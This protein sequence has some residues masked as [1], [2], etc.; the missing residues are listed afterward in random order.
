MEFKIDQWHG[1]EVDFL[2]AEAL[3]PYQF[4]E[5]ENLDGR[6]VASAL[7]PAGEQSRTLTTQS[8][9]MMIPGQGFYEYRAEWDDESTPRQISTLYRV[10]AGIV[11]SAGAWE[12]NIRRNNAK[13]DN[14]G[15]W[16]TE[17]I[18]ET[19][20]KGTW[21]RA[22]S[23]RLVQ[24]ST[25][26]SFAA[27][28]G[29]ISGHA[30]LANYEVG[31]IIRVWNTTSNNGYYTV[32]AKEPAA[33]SVD[34][35]ESL[36]DEA[37]V[38]AYLYPLPDIS[39]FAVN[40]DLRVSNGN[41]VDS[42]AS[43]WYGHIKRDFWGQGITYASNA[44]R[45]NQPPMKE[46]YNNW[47]LQN[48]ELVAPTV[49]AGDRTGQN[50]SAANQIAIHV[51]GTHP[52]NWPD[53]A[54]DVE[55]NARDR[56]TATFVYD[57]VQESE[58]GKLSSGDIGIEMSTIITAGD[59]RAFMVEAYTGA[60]QASWN[61]RITAIR[62]YYKFHDDPDWYEIATLDINK[63]W[64]ESEIVFD[65]ENTGYWIPIAD[66][67]MDNTGTTN[68]SGGSGTT[69]NDDGHGLATDD[70][71]YFLNT[72]TIE[73]GSM[74]TKPSSF[75]TNT[76]T[77]PVAMVD[78]LGVN[79]SYNSVEWCAGDRSATAVA[80]FYI[81]FTGEKAFSYFTNTGRS[82]KIKVPAIRWRACD[83]D[84]SK[85][86]YGN[87]DTK[88]DNDQTIRERSRIIETSAG[89]PDTALLSN[90]KD[91][92]LYLGDEIKAIKYYNGYWWV[93]MERHVLVIQPGTLRI[94]QAYSNSGC[95]WQSAFAVTPYGM[96]VADETKITILPS[97]EELTFLKRE[98][99]QALTFFECNM[100]Y[101]KKMNEL[102][103][104]PDSSHPGDAWLEWVYSFSNKSWRR[105]IKT[106]AGF[107]TF[108]ASNYHLNNYNASEYCWSLVT[109]GT[110][111][112][113]VLEISEDITQTSW[114]TAIKTKEYDHD[115][116]NN[117]KQ[118]GSGYLVHKSSGTITVEIYLDGSSTA[119][120]TREISASSSSFTSSEIQL[121]V[122][123]KFLELRFTTVATTTVEYKEFRIPN[124][125][126]TVLDR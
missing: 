19:A 122:Q 84:G 24:G 58:L 110:T 117:E 37:S 42:H 81:P 6:H 115:F 103:F 9:L 27:T 105:Y 92:G 48:Q 85:V 28:T 80:T 111:Y 18:D 90:S 125:E 63:G 45:F 47:K 1:G 4:Q 25:N 76:M 88:D 104:M 33:N 96:C 108:T 49:I 54:V 82:A 62:L 38:S 91:V 50:T 15:T 70:M 23:S 21:E 101:D 17:F 102:R 7:N 64:S 43:Q 86:L 120:G 57:F 121:N 124:E 67:T 51:A 52:S 83:T 71:V 55:W 89:M 41:F 109:A 31:E 22:T 75:A 98:T 107:T 53:K 61:R 119:Y 59:A 123:C 39:M 2:K 44:G 66:G 100:G 8:A 12:I 87:I 29:R 65:D 13:N 118:F 10:I 97:G 73:P 72:A 94:V 113:Y 11:D 14:V 68:P 3:A 56:V 116:P 32:K 106:T 46:A 36:T 74:I 112:Y 5:F 99:Y 26:I 114:A 40:G 34:V 93:M 35:Q 95:K 77:L 69:V 16:G 78:S 20:T 60:S 30:N 79:S 126:I